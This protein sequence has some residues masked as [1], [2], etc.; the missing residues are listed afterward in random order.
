[1]GI[2]FPKLRLFHGTEECFLCQIL[3][4][5]LVF[6]AYVADPIYRVNMPRVEL[7]KCCILLR[8]ETPPIAPEAHFCKRV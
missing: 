3:C 2:I 8:H 4:V 6:H 7:R 5:C 1:M